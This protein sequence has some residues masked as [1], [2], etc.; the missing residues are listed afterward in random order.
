MLR[1]LRLGI[2]QATECV[3]SHQVLSLLLSSISKN[4][5]G[6]SEHFTPL[7]TDLS[8]QPGTLFSDMISFSST[9][10]AA[11]DFVISE[12]PDDTQSPQLLSMDLSPTPIKILIDTGATTS[13]L[14]AITLEKLNTPHRFGQLTLS[15]CERN[16]CASK[17]ATD[18]QLFITVANGAR[19]PVTRS[20]CV[21]LQF[22]DETIHFRVLVVAALAGNTVLHDTL[23]LGKDLLTKLGY[24]VT[25]EGEKLGPVKLSTL[26]A[27]PLDPEFAV[28]S[29]V[30][31]SEPKPI[32]VIDAVADAS[33]VS[34]RAISYLDPYE[35]V[36]KWLSS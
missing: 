21:N 3:T 18:D 36:E 31:H 25:T 35:V 19:I 27:L 13:V 30:L 34:D 9:V 32:E 16:E 15:V 12:T 14:S 2:P 29:A 20:A 28:Y 10:P 24:S 7:L 1:S 6:I 23:V 4:Q 8:V 33:A 5:D 26:V 17:L 11:P 22:G